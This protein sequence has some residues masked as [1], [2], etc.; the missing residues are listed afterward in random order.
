MFNCD[1]S[2]FPL[3][4][5]S[6]QKV[7]VD[8]MVTRDFHL[9][10]SSKTSITKLQCI[11]ASGFVLLSAVYFPGKS[12]NLEL[13]IGFPKNVFLGFSDS[14]WMET[15]HF[16]GCIAN[17]FVKQIPSKRPVILLLEGHLSH[18]DY[19]TSL[20]CK[21]NEIHLFRLRPRTSHVMDPADTGF[22]NVF[23]GEWKKV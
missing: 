17:F 9:S 16:Y 19:N 4:A 13:C 14:G 8:Q 22:F 12:L 5:C 6:W 20:F 11:S 1:E 18:V 23:K 10:N 2:G 21:A 15:Y 7:C 3:Q